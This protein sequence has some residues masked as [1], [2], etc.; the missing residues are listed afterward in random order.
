[1]STRRNARPGALDQGMGVDIP[2]QISQLI[3]R[4]ADDPYSRRSAKPGKNQFGQDRL[5]LKQEKRAQK[6][7]CGVQRYGQAERM[8]YIG[9]ERLFICGGGHGVAVQCT[10]RGRRRPLLPGRGRRWRTPLRTLG[11]GNCP[12][13]RSV[14]SGTSCAITM[15]VSASYRVQ[16]CCE[17]SNDTLRHLFPAVVDPRRKMC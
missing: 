13:Y 4:Q 2:E 16:V 10:S 1:M 14:T 6:N 5:D 15:E 11:P 8:F 7:R 12:R 3:E 9:G 17:Y